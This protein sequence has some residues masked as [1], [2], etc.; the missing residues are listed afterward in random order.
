[1]PLIDVTE[2][3]IFAG[4]PRKCR[5]CAVAIAINRQLKPGYAASVAQGNILIA[6]IDAMGRMRLEGYCWDTPT[7][8]AARDMIKALD[9]RGGATQPTSFPL[10]IPDRFLRNPLANKQSS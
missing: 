7:P 4:V 8:V 9:G 1:M 3:D 10:D 5:E 2:E 6:A